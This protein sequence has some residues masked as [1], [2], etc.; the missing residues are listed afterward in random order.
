MPKFK[1]YLRQRLKVT[2]SHHVWRERLLAI[3]THETFFLTC[4][5]TVA[6]QAWFEA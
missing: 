5:G 4:I 6:F 1:I 3:L 2:T